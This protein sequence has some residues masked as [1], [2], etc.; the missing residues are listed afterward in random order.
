[1]CILLLS[2]SVPHP[3]WAFQ[4][5]MGFAFLFVYIIRNSRFN[6]LLQF[7]VIGSTQQ[8][9]CFH[10]RSIL[11]EL[12]TLHRSWYGWRVYCLVNWKNL[13]NLALSKVGVVN[14]WEWNRAFLDKLNWCRR[15][16]INRI[17]MYGCCSDVEEPVSSDSIL[18]CLNTWRPRNVFRILTDTKELSLLQS[19]Q[20]RSCTYTSLQLKNSGSWGILTPCKTAWAWNYRI[21]PLPFV[22]YEWGEL[23]F[24]CYLQWWLGEWHLSLNYSYIFSVSAINL[25]T[26]I[27]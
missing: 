2:F 7:N 5:L 27:I 6:V 23:H 14:I 18:T 17:A 15:K 10:R 3:L 26:S 22:G 16:Y 4:Q 25:G 21:I 19:V 24:Y 20:K 1:M 11:L 9:N 12:L 13:S 8:R